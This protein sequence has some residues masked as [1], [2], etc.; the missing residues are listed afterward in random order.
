MQQQLQLQLVGKACIDGAELGKGA[1][2]LL[3]MQHQQI[4]QG[5]LQTVLIELS[6]HRMGSATGSHQPAGAAA[7]GQGQISRLPALACRRLLLRAVSTSTVMG[8]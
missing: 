1:A 8:R 5:Q 6:V 7:R 4:G 2:A 3:W